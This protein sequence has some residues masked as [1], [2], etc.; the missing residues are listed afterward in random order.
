[1]RK[2]IKKAACNCHTQMDIGEVKVADDQDFLNLKH[3]V[4]DEPGWTLEFNKESTKVWTKPA[5]TTS[6]KMVKVNAVFSNVDPDVLYD[7]LHDPEYRKVWDTHMVEQHDIGSLNPNNDLGYY[8]MTCPSPVSKR[9]FV[10]QRSWL[11][12][13][14][15]KYIINHSVYHKGF[16][17]RKDFIRAKSYITGFLVRPS[18]THGCYLD[19]VSQS[20][21]CGKLPSVLVN[22]LTQ[23]VARKMVAT[24]QEACQG[25][26]E[27]KR[28]HNPHWKPWHNPEQMTKPRVRLEDCKPSP[29]DMQLAGDELDGDKS[30]GSRKK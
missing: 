29:A 26:P 22:K 15:E 2:S 9:D 13:G 21:P 18:K 19:Y 23:K 28:Q 5:P 14:Q 25:Y 4:E 7:V 3:L 1:M 27:W 12:T 17:P 24:L 6:F 30:S 10:L 16:P 8:A 20:D 11:D